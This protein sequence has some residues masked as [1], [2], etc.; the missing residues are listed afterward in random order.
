MRWRSKWDFIAVGDTRYITK[1]LLFPKKINR[2]WRWL[3]RA[4]ILQKCVERMNSGSMDYGY[5]KAWMDIQWI[6][7]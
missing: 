4:T 1:F 7:R 3:E 6:K 2:E 5:H